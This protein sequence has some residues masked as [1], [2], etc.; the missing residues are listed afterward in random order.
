LEVDEG[1]KIF[2]FPEGAVVDFYCEFPHVGHG[3]V[4]KA[5]GV[6]NTKDQLVDLPS[7]F[8]EFDF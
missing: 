3:N 8:D 5:L 6:G 7:F 2:G 4:A 1:G